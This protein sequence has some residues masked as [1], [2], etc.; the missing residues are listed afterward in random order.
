MHGY[1]EYY[2]NDGRKYIGQFKVITG[3]YILDKKDGF[4][5]YIW[6]DTRAYIGFWKDGKQHGTGKYINEGTI[7]YDQWLK[8][9]RVKRYDNEE[10]AL[11][12][13]PENDTMFS[14][15]F[16]YELLDIAAYYNF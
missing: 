16:V 3:F 5:I 7:R 13:I 10:E 2:W 9:K 14:K 4:G 12:T 11:S 6:N 1:G 8:G 15:F